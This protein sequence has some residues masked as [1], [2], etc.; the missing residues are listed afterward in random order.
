MPEGIFITDRTTI[1]T[2]W[3]C[4]MKRWWYKHALGT[5]IVPVSEASYYRVG[6]DIHTLL[7]GVAEA[8]DLDNLVVQLELGWRERVDEAQTLTLKEEI[9]RAYGWAMAWAIYIEPGIRQRYETISLEHE[10]VLQRDPLWLVTTPDRVLRDRDTH[11]IVVDDY[12]TT[13]GSM[14]WDAYWPYAIQVHIQLK[15][16][17]EELGQKP[18][19]GRVRGLLKGFQRDG[20]LIHPY[21]WAWREP[22]QDYK[23]GLTP[24][25]VW[26]YGSLGA[27]IRVLGSEVALN[28]FPLSM[29]IFCNDRLLDLLIERRIERETEVSNYLE[30]AKSTE[31]P[32]S[33][34][35]IIFEPRYSQCRPPGR[36]R[37]CPYLACCHNA[38]VSED[39]LG[40]GLYV[41]RTPHHEL[42][43]VG[44]DD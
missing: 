27:W 21:V 5:G 32:L 40:S 11:E 18:K 42:E 30:I 29:P 31:M 7:Q 43:I 39:P 44:V 2:D 38:T 35:Q 3:T 23:P 17:E 6:R 1:E 8:S 16:V 14:G 41:T 13:S 15:A 4:G 22:G 10:L 37:Q 34:A 19:Y 28:Q 33:T 12:K 24:V 20:R 26:E 36:E 25:P 9:T